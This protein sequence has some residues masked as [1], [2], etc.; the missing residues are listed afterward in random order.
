MD[1][2][3]NSSWRYLAWKLFH[4][5]ISD[6]TEIYRYFLDKNEYLKYRENILSTKIVRLVARKGVLSFQRH[7]TVD[8]SGVMSPEFVLF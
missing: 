3:I 6:C 7:Y 5:S 4:R 8:E 1:L 2:D